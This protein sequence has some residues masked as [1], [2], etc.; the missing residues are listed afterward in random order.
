[1]F[2]DLDDRQGRTGQ[3]G[4]HC[5]FRRNVLVFRVIA[6]LARQGLGQVRSRDGTEG[7]GVDETD[8]VVEV[9][10]EL[11]VETLDVFLGR[12]DGLEVLVLSATVDGVVD[13]H[14]VHIRIFVGLFV[15]VSRSALHLVSPQATKEE[16]EKKCTTYLEDSFF[17]LDPHAFTVHPF[18]CLTDKS[19]FIGDSQGLTSLLGELGIGPGVFLFSSEDTDQVRRSRG[20][21]RRGESGKKLRLEGCGYF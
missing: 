7:E 6:R 20:K 1:M 11:V 12:D 10:E 4:F 17:N 19:K 2:E 13:H 15:F 18:P 5:T 8:V 21:A 9:E 3:D 14:A 16:E